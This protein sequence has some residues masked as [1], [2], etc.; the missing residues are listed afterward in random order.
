LTATADA[1]LH[2]LISRTATPLDG[3]AKATEL[4]RAK[5][6][7]NTANL[8]ILASWNDSKNYPEL[9]NNSGLY[10]SGLSSM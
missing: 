3:R 10:I 1:K 9:R 4:E 6:I 8:F 2:T 7:R 5:E